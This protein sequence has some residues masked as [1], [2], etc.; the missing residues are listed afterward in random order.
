MRHVTEY[1]PAKTG[2]YPRIFPN[3]QNCSRCRKVLKDNKYNSVRGAVV[4]W[5][6]HSTPEQAVRVQAL[7][8]DNVLRSWARHFTLTVPFS[9][10]VYEWVP[11]NCWLN[12]TNCGLRWTS[13]LSR[14][15]RNTSSRRARKNTP[16]RVGFSAPFSTLG[17]ALKQSLVCARSPFEFKQLCLYVFQ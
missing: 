5:L 12:L 11:V 9:T 2:E 13:I 17:N 16:L 4:S 1:S 6:V 10:Q 8:G 7:A 15:R 14:G 3:F